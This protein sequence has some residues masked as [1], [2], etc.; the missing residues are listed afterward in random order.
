MLLTSSQGPAEAPTRPLTGAVSGLG[1]SWISRTRTH[2]TCLRCIDHLRVMR[3]RVRTDCSANLGAV[4]CLYLVCTVVCA[5]RHHSP[6]V[7]HRGADAVPQA[8]VAVSADGDAAWPSD[9]AILRVVQAAQDHS[10][11]VSEWGSRHARFP[12]G[13]GAQFSIAPT[14]VRRAGLKALQLFRVAAAACPRGNL[15]YM[16][17]VVDGRDAA[18]VAPTAAGVAAVQ[19][20]AVLQLWDPALAATA[21]AH[22]ASVAAAYHQLPLQPHTMPTESGALL[23]GLRAGVAPCLMP[24]ACLAAQLSSL[25][26]DRP[27]DAHDGSR[28]W[29][30]RVWGTA[31]TRANNCCR[32][33]SPASGDASPSAEHRAVA[34]C[35]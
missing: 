34:W 22:L 3:L 5:L 27:C 25:R 26:C 9:E 29:P 1:I 11:V 15:L 18:H 33:T 14:Q 12:G 30:P 10:S 7:L 23:H 17:G 31:V 20:L 8:V 32:W 35:L 28:G 24:M 21:T 4:S 6:A 13:L 19:S 16:H 2:A